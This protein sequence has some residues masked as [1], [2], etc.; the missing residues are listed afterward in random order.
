MRKLSQQNCNA[1]HI[2]C[3]AKLQCTHI[4]CP[5]KLQCT[6]HYM[7]SKIA[8]TYIAYS[9]KLHWLNHGKKNKISRKKLTKK[10]YN[11]NKIIIQ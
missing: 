7:P 8:R 5:A 1:H 11:N 3:P 6:P 9:G 4:T 2:T 10:T